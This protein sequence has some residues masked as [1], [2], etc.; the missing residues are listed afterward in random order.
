MD[1][2]TSYS[3]NI[4][5]ILTDYMRQHQQATHKPG[6]E[7]E[8]QLMLDPERH[9]YQI[10]YV[11]WENMQRVYYPIFHLDIKEGK[12]WVQ[13]AA[14]E[15]DIVGALEDRGVPKSDI[16]LAFHAPYK[17]PFTEYAAA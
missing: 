2:L 4:Q 6:D 3:K 13:E 14:S 9:H 8:A 5:Q 17:R 10:V 1:R 16:V 11:G 12:I 7:M 15:F